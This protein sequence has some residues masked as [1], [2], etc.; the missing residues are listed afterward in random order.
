LCR[1]AFALNGS[2]PR[3]IDRSTV[4][5]DVQHSYQIHG[6]EHGRDSIKTVRVLLLIG[7]NADQHKGDAQLNRDDSGAVEHFKEEEELWG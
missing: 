1:V 2:V 4:E 7:S 5:Y 3:I 6:G